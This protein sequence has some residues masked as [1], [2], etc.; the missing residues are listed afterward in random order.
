METSKSALVH[1]YICIHD[2]VRSTALLA[3]HGIPKGLCHCSD[4]ASVLCSMLLD[5]LLL[6]ISR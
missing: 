1:R 3:I 2:L 4:H 5:I 6:V